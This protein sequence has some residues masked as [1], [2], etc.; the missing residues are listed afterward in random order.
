MMYDVMTMSNDKKIIKLGQ[1][2]EKELNKLTEADNT[3][4]ATALIYS[5]SELMATSYSIEDEIML[6]ELVQEAALFA[7]ELTEGVSLVIEETKTTNKIIH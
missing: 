5:I 7:V 3:V 4:L 6:S 2:P 1:L